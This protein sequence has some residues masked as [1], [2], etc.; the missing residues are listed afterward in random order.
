M[1]DAPATTRPP[2]RPD[3]AALSGLEQMRALQAGVFPYHGI[4]HTLGFRLDEVAEGRVV[5]AGTPGPETYNPLGTVHGGYAATLLDSA[6][7]C[8]V[9]TRLAPGQGYTTLE[10][11][12]AYHRPMTADTG[13]VRAEGRVTQFGRR[14]A[15]TEA[16]LTDAAGKLIASATSTLMVL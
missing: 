6:C 2:A 5:F 10:I 7:G 15:F 11:K 12:V 1:T 8:A 13:E 9:H 14:A 16:T 4:G 3:F